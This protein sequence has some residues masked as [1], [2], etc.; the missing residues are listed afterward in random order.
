MH[1]IGAPDVLPD[2]HAQVP[3]NMGEFLGA[4]QRGVFKSALP[5]AQ[6]QL[7]LIPQQGNIGM[8]RGHV[9][10]VVHGT[11]AVYQIIHVAVKEI[12]GTVDAGQP[13]G[14][15][16]QIGAAQVQVYRMQRAQAAA[17]GQDPAVPGGE[18]QCPGNDFFANI[19]VP[20]FLHLDAGPGRPFAVPAFPVDTVHRDQQQ[21]SF[22]QERR[23]SLNHPVVLKIVKT[24]ALTGERDTGLAALPVD[25]ELHIPVQKPA[26]LL[27]ITHFHGRHLLRIF[28]GRPHRPQ[29]MGRHGRKM[30]LLALQ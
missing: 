3:Q 20:A 30:L 11:V 12:G 10:H 22:F 4:G 29:C 6:D 17:R 25:L 26:G 8:I 13:D 5:G 2:I 18:F 19:V 24:P 7:A 15:P 1:H 28:N 23:H 21:A 9:G 14:A 16:H 27:E